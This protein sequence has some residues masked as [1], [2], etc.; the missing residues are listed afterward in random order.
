MD[1]AVTIDFTEPTAY[2]I[3][4]DLLQKL[5]HFEDI[6]LPLVPRLRSTLA[7]ITTLSRL[8]GVIPD[9]H[10]G[11]QTN[12]VMYMDEAESFRTQ[13]QGYIDSA[14]LMKQRSH[15]TLDIVSIWH[16]NHHCSQSACSN[17]SLV[18]SRP[19]STESEEGT[20]VQ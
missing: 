18:S 17:L 2:Q 7:T 13:V 15:R 9:S 8:K 14:E 3:G 16:M 10:L 12:Q 6:I 19:E 11:N 20:G 4:S 5:Q 1:I